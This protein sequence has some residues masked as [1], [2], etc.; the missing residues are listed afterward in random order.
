VVC[1]LLNTQI[2]HVNV[3]V[4]FVNISVIILNWFSVPK[5]CSSEQRERIYTL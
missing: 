3:W 1:N 4:I 5:F 2:I